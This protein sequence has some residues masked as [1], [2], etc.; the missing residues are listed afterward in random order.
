MIIV[1]FTFKIALFSDYL[2]FKICPY[3]SFADLEVGEDTLVMVA[4]HIWRRKITSNMLGL[5]E[6]QFV[7]FCILLGNDFTKG[8]NVDKN[9]GD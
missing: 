7:E 6:M 5:N 3:I 8:L 1:S 4:K 9:V 2:A